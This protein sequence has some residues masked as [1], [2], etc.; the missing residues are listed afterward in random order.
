[1]VSKDTKLSR[2]AYK[3]IFPFLFVFC[4]FRWS[5]GCDFFGYMN[6]HEHTFSGVSLDSAVYYREPGYLLVTWF[7]QS[8]NLPWYY[9]NIVGAASFF[10]GIHVIARREPNPLLYLTLLFPIYIMGL[11]MSA[12]R[13]CLASGFVCLAFNAFTDKKLARYVIFVGLAAIF[14]NSAAGFA[15]VVVFLFPGSATLKAFFGLALTSPIVFVLA[16]S[17]TMQ[18]YT[19]MYLGSGVEAEGGRYRAIPGF[20]TGLLF[21]LFMRKRWRERYADYETIFIFSF[22]MIAIM[23]L[24]FVSSVMGDRFGYYLMPLVYA[25]QARAHKLFP[26]NLSLVLVIAPLLVAVAYFLAW[27][28]LS[29]QFYLCYVPYQTLWSAQ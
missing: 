1:M 9:I 5:V 14:H 25:I 22:A 18:T 13:Q 28:T 29:W 24:V 21:M 15:S 16:R 4:A 23:G 3:I 17:D 8:L 11:G 7:I 12:V 27:T 20:L 2:T 19:N 6:L 10:L 26:Q